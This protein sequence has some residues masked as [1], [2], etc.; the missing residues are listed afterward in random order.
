MQAK[1][2]ATTKIADKQQSNSLKN[3]QLKSRTS[4]FAASFGNV[5]AYDFSKLKSNLWFEIDECLANKIG[6][7]G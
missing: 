2:L 1:I 6:K 4:V 7:L 5:L 3:A